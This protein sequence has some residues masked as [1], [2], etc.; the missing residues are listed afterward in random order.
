MNKELEN[1]FSYHAPTPEQ[2]AKYEAV[3]SMAKQFAYFL[4]EVTPSSREQSTALT[5]PDEVVFFANA[6][7]ARRSES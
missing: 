3:R 1:R 7:I 2:P 4:L 6:A 5:K